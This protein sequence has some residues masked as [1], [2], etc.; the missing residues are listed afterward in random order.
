MPTLHISDAEAARDL[1][2]LMR[3]VY[4]G[5][6]VIIDNGA[7]TVA[8]VRSSLPARKS[9]PETLS[10]PRQHEDATND[11]PVEVSESRAMVR[12]PLVPSK[13][14]GTLNLKDFNFD[15]LLA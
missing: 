2:A 12:L 13:Q 9:L 5:D 15:D 8:V 14:A 4:D 3:R 7:L 6:E 10:L 11:T 1:S